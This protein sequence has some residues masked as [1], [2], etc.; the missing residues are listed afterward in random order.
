MRL[1][2]IWTLPRMSLRERV[3]RT[4]ELFWMK[5]AAHLPERLAYWSYIHQG[6]KHFEGNELVPEVRYMTVLDRM[7]K[8]APKTW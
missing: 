1:R 2:T 7:G 8:H 6:V 3:S 4:E 5:A